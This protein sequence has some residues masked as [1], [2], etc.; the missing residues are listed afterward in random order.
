MKGLAFLYFEIMHAHLSCKQWKSALAGMIVIKNVEK[1]GIGDVGGTGASA[2][3]VRRNYTHERT[4]A[5][6]SKTCVKLVH[7]IQTLGD[8][9]SSQVVQAKTKAARRGCV[10][11]PAP[12]LAKR[13]PAEVAGAGPYIQRCLNPKLYS[14]LL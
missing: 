3:S 13:L 4:H 12:C 7:R 6:P 5:Y 14:F 11:D 10:E 8:S 1:T 9:K 2:I